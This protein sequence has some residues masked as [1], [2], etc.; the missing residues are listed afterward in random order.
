MSPDL[1]LILRN[2]SPGAKLTAQVPGRVPAKISRMVLLPVGRTVS[3][4]QMEENLREKLEDP[5]F[6]ADIKPLLAPGIDWNL[7]AASDL[8]FLGILPL[9]PG[10]PWKGSSCPSSP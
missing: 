3:R 10:E 8:L 6:L 1:P 4:A 9:I 2:P 5:H 7:Q